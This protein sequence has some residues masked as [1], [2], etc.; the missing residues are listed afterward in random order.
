MHNISTTKLQN[1]KLCLELDDCNTPDKDIDWMRAIFCMGE[2]F[3]M[4][5][6]AADRK[7][8]FCLRHVGLRYKTLNYKY[9]ISITKANGSGSI[10]AY[11]TSKYF[12]C[13]VDN[14]FREN[15][16]AVFGKKYY[17]WYIRKDGNLQYEVHISRIAKM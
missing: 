16:C 4:N 17:K 12:L 7:I 6:R 14:I 8:R 1:G 10:S 15:K 5:I 3:F 13:D 11:S 2:I 9:K